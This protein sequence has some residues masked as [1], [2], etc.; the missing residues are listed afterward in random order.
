MSSSAETIRSLEGSI[1]VM[2][3]VS[4]FTYAVLPLLFDTQSELVSF[5]VTVVYIVL[6]VCVLLLLV[7]LVLLL[8]NLP[9]SLALQ[10]LALPYLA[11]P[12][13][14]LFHLAFLPT[15]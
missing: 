10:F 8:F 2:V 5:K 12:I 9:C 1:D 3:D 7:L 14:S 11:F 15:T 13:L 6:V 4:T